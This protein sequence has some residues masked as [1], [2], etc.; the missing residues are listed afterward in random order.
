MTKD[1]VVEQAGVKPGEAVHEALLARAD[2][3]AMTQA[4]H[5]AALLPEDPGGIS[6]AQRAALACRISRRHGDAGLTSHYDVL[7]RKASATAEVMRVADPAYTGEGRIGALIAYTDLASMVPRD[8]GADD[9]EAL[10]AAG[11]VDADIVRLAEL[12][13]FLAYQIRLIAGLKLLRA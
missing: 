12:N 4:T 11:I 10:K 6:H 2:I 13:A 7:M 3:L 9:I 5:D 8:V 1:V